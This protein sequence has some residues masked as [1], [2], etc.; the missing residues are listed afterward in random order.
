MVEEQ[1][2]R[3][4]TGPTKDEDC[5]RPVVIYHAGCLDGFGAAYAAWRKF[6]DRAEYMPAGYGKVPSLRA[7]G[8]ATVYL[9]DY[10]I[11]RKEIE[12]WRKMRKV[13]VIDHHQSAASELEGLDDCI[14]DMNQSGAVLAWKY[15]CPGEDVPQLLRHIED[16][17]LWRFRMDQTR[18]ICAALYAYDFDFA[19]FDEMV[20]VEPLDTLFQ[21]GIAIRRWQE[22]AAIQ[23]IKNP[24]VIELDKV[25]IGPD[26]CLCVNA[27]YM[28]AS[29]VCDRMIVRLYAKAQSER[30]LIDD[31]VWEGF[32]GV[33][34]W[35]GF[36]A[37]WSFMDGKYVYQL[38]G[39]GSVDVSEIAKMYGGGGHKHAA[40]F[41]VADKIPGYPLRNYW[42]DVKET[43]GET[44]AGR[45]E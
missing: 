44:A 39:K 22:K 6:G 16:R 7:D 32:S 27:P 17:D 29:D 28:L 20:R 5:D 12:Q 23:L 13:V 10:S 15:F 41:A 45:R 3:L 42:S 21:E 31:K 18:E 26:E 19:G 35:H 24:E 38:R 36:V 8:R 1:N 43:S 14:F 30:P 4:Q 37:S 11:P 9:V 33:S 25:A 40:G 34:G 2:D